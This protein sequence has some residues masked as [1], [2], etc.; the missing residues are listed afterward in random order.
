MHGLSMPSFASSRQIQHASS[1]GVSRTGT[2]VRAISQR[3]ARIRGRSVNA[4]RE[5]T[6]RLST[7]RA[8][9]VDWVVRASRGVFSLAFS[10]SRRARRDA[11]T[12][13]LGIRDPR[14]RLGA[15][16]IRAGHHRPV[17]AGVERCAFERRSR[18]LAMRLGSTRESRSARV[19]RARRGVGH[20]SVRV[21]A[22]DTRE[23]RERRRAGRE[24]RARVWVWRARRRSDRD[25]TLYYARNKY[26]T[27]F[28][29]CSRLTIHTRAASD[30]QDPT[31]ELA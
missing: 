23:T 20:A 11:A 2:R 13:Y 22:G 8:R 6:P 31:P 19:R 15:S 29:V 3:R 4:Y 25:E 14:L 10:P 12:T 1:S 16:G 24:G 30:A 21:D 7:R 27:H 28:T 18:Q 5:K 9:R 17:Q 26:L